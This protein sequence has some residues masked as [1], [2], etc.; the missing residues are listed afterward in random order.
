MLKQTAMLI[1]LVIILW[2][3]KYNHWDDKGSNPANCPNHITTNELPL[4]AESTHML[5]QSKQRAIYF[6]FGEPTFSKTTIEVLRSELAAVIASYVL[7]VH[8]IIRYH[9]VITVSHLYRN[10]LYVCF[11]INI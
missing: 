7:V 11:L 3:T 8:I 10:L 6:L 1:F 5:L 4:F 9:A 2:I